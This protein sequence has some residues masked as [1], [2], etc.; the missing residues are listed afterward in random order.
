[1]SQ[2]IIASNQALSVDG[3]S[4]LITSERSF[5]KALLAAPEQRLGNDLPKVGA[6]FAAAIGCDQV[7]VMDADMTLAEGQ[8]RLSDRIRQLAPIA[9]CHYVL[10]STDRGLGQATS[11]QR[12]EQKNPVTDAAQIEDDLA[13]LAAATI[14]L[15]VVVTAVLA[16]MKGVGAGRVCVH[17]PEAWQRGA[18][19][20]RIQPALVDYISRWALELKSR[21]LSAYPG[22]TLEVKYY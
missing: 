11:A 10:L 19:G 20:S 13:L 3:I 15:T 1:M 9:E 21:D 14:G 4:E 18:N 8:G 7:E 5:D 22:L 16:M 17:V 12:A 6:A 2:L